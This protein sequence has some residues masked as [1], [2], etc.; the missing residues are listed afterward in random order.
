MKEKVVPRLIAFPLISPMTKE[1]R[2]KM[3]GNTNIDRE[4]NYF[5]VHQNSGEEKVNVQSELS[6]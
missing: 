4:M 3:H 6:I 1:I 5:V 2:Q